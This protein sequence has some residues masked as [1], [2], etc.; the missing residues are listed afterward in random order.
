MR[1]WLIALTAVLAAPAAAALAAPPVE[2][3]A[4]RLAWPLACELGR[5]CF[6]QRYVDRLPGPG[7]RDYTCGS[8]TQDNHNGTDIRLRDM[9]DERRGVD[10]LAAAPG[11]VAR[12]R[13]G[14]PDISVRDRGLAAVKGT[15]CGNGVVIAHGNGWETQYC[16]MAKGSIVVHVGQT[17][18]AGAPLGHVGLSGETE[19]PHL[20][21]G[22]RHGTQGVDPFAPEPGAG[23][24][25]GAGPSLWTKPPP[26]V[27]R[28]VINAGFTDRALTMAD[29]EAGGLT[30]P[31]P[32]SAIV[33][34]YVRVIDLKAGDVVSLTLRG[35][36]GVV[37]APAK[38]PALAGPDQQH[39][40]LAGKRRPAQGWPRG[41]YRGEFTVENGGRTVLSRTVEITL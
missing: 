37:L 14:E 11:Q 6:I 3:G 29:I 10:V 8:N 28:Q 15:E 1:R 33:A 27:A 41:L 35:P 22:V 39:F 34:A 26:Y 20:H 30:P 16:H 12:L 40:I 18:A 32:N 7:A 13:D 2:A 25:C 31:T 5:T 24:A 17:V 4:P 38:Q 9:D 23:G 36:G 19:F 21:I